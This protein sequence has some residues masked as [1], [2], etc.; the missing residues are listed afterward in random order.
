M[1]GKAWTGPLLFAA[2]VLALPYLLTNDYYLSTLTI[3]FLN[4]IIVVGL[5]LLLGYAGQISL[6]HGAFYGLAAYTTAVVTTT[7]GMPVIVGLVAGV[8]MA[9]LV[10]WIIGIPT[11]KLHGHY[12][13]M[14]TLG[15]G[16]IVYIFFNETIAL[17]G[18]PSGF[19]GVPRLTLL[20]FAFESDLS[21]YY[22]VGLVLALILL[23]SGNLIDSRL[24]RAL[25][26]IH[27]SEKAAQVVGIDIARYKLFIFVLSAAY[28]GVAGV[29][30]A[31]YLMFVAPSSF[32]FLFSVLL[33]VMVVLGGMANIWGAVAGAVF[34]TVLPEFLRAFDEI[35]ILLYGLILVL[36]MIFLPEGIAG[37][38]AR[39]WNAA[40]WR[41]K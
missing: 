31:H 7:L 30:Y 5:N 38:A 29:L 24:G 27:T 14:A 15:F 28:A 18:G 12:L 23:L 16:I 26:A 39:L 4:A 36:C 21:Y 41:N 13:A 32:G 33:I 3:A 8:A 22:L 1:F 35:E 25:K 9:A 17:T 37:G 10:A 19:V 40:P 6:G 11:L 34:L 20:G 2:L